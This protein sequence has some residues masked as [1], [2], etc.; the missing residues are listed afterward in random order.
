[1]SGIVAV[2]DDIAEWTDES[3]RLDILFN[4]VEREGVVAILEED[5]TAVSGV[6]R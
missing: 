3:Y 6:E 1:L 4:G 5:D 2:V